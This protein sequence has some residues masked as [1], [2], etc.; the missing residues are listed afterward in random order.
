M[1]KYI[2]ILLILVITFSLAAYDFPYD[3]GFG[4]EFSGKSDS[5]QLV[6][7]STYHKI[8]DCPFFSPGVEINVDL[9]ASS[10]GIK[11]GGV[12]F[13]AM[14]DLFYLE[15][16]VFSSISINPTLWSPS[17]KVGF[18]WNDEFYP[19]FTLEVAAFR[20]LEKDFV[21][22]WFSPFVNFNEDGINSWGLTFCRFTYMCL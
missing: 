2:L 3:S 21:Y 22:E 16:K 1:K 5:T 20:F 6:G 7:I 13:L 15:N 18:F 9:S 14:F 19:N 17:I 10:K 12:R 4:F 8:M 11:F